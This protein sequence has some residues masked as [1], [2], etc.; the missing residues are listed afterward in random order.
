MTNLCGQCKHWHE[1]STAKKLKH[2]KENIELAI[3]YGLSYYFS[4]I[5]SDLRL[6][7]CDKIGRGTVY[8]IEDGDAGNEYDGNSF[9]DE[10]YTDYFNCFEQREEE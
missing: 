9:E 4:A 10:C 3:K 6:G 8:H 7:D 2:D 1:W 5:H